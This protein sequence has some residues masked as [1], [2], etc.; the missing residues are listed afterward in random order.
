MEC[1]VDHEWSVGWII[2]GVWGGSSMECGVDH[3]WSVG[4]IMNGVW[5]G[6]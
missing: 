5:G 1:G 2:N 6:S 3:Q 4:W